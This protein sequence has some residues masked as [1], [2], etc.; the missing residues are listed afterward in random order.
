M[1]CGVLELDVLNDARLGEIFAAEIQTNVN[2]FSP[3]LN[4]FVLAF[5]GGWPFHRDSN[6]ASCYIEQLQALARGPVVVEVITIAAEAD[7][8][9]VGHSVLLIGGGSIRVSCNRSRACE[10]ATHLIQLVTKLI[11]ISQFDDIGIEYFKTNDLGK[12]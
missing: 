9:D 12:Q 2:Q 8:V 3:L 10:V 4:S 11:S 1:S 6:Q 5:L 7:Q